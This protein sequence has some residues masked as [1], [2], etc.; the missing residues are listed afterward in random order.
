MSFKES[1]D[2]ES[3]RADFDVMGKLVVS[4]EKISYTIGFLDSLIS[5]NQT[6]Y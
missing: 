2:V 4:Y 1:P 5:S 3:V 6:I